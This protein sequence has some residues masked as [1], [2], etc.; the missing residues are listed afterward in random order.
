MLTCA[1]CLAAFLAPPPLRGAPTALRPALPPPHLGSAPRHQPLLA[2]PPRRAAVPPQMILGAGKLWPNSLG[3][4]WGLHALFWAAGAGTLGVLGRSAAPLPL[5]AANAALAAMLYRSRED[6]G[7]YLSLTAAAYFCGCG[8]MLW[9]TPLSP[10]LAP[11]APCLRWL[12]LWHCA[13]AFG[14]LLFAIKATLKDRREPPHSSLLSHTLLLFPTRARALTPPPPKQALLLRRPARLA[15]A[16]LPA[17]EGRNGQPAG[18][19][20]RHRRD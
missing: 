16:R 1:L 11:F 19:R 7:S 3:K 2:P 6:A 20:G 12:R 17:A 9:R 8:L 15:A 14:S 5:A 4:F 13:L 10:L 18:R